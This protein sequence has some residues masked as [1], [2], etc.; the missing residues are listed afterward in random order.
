MR[1]ECHEPGLLS[2]HAL[3]RR[4]SLKPFTS[5]TPTCTRTHNVLMCIYTHSPTQPNR[6]TLRR[7]PVVAGLVRVAVKDFELSGGC[8]NVCISYQQHLLVG[9]PHAMRQASSPAASSTQSHWAAGA[10]G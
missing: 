5:N 6:E 9:W 2:A 3:P 4:L 8:D 7:D 10:G 1:T